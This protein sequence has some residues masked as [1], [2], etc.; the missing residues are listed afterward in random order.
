LAVDT[1]P[2]TVTAKFKIT[3]GRCIRSNTCFDAKL[4]PKTFTVHR[5]PFGVRRSAFGAM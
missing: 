2:S 4:F 5:S 1:L 3:R